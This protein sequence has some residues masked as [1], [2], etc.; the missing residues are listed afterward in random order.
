M[1]T[2]IATLMCMTVLAGPAV[3]AAPNQDH[4]GNFALAQNNGKYTYTTFPDLLPLYVF[5][6]DERGKSKCDKPCT[7]VWQIV[8]APENAQPTGDWTTF[9]R[10]DGR[11]QWAYKGKPVYTFY[12]D[13]AYDPP[14]GENLPYGWWLT[15]G[16][17][18]PAQDSYLKFKSKTPVSGPIWRIL[19][20]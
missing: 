1:R 7:G 9:K 13:R 17:A 2:L 3:A 12:D 11:F 16:V 14:K 20:P 6:G 19:E 5:D 18:G 4:P 8:R 10:D 15:E